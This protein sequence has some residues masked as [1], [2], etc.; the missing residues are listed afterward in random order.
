MPNYRKDQKD[1]LKAYLNQ[2]TYDGAS[3]QVHTNSKES[4]DIYPCIIIQSSASKLELEDNATYEVS[5][6]YLLNIVQ[7][8]SDSE[9]LGIYN[10]DNF[11]EVEGLIIDKLTSRQVRDDTTSPARWFDLQIVEITS[12]YDGVIRLTN[13]VI[14]KTIRINIRSNILF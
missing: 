1:R 3:L 14:I 5:N 2:I 6:E 12:P 7:L 9:V 11:E 10:E 4:P 13:N 8:P